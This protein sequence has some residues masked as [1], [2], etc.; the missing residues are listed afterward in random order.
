MLAGGSLALAAGLAINAFTRAYGIS[1][2]GMARSRDAA[3]AVEK[4]Q[5][6]L[7]PAMLGTVCVALSL[8][9]PEVLGALARVAHSVIGVNISPELVVGNLTVIPAHLDF[10]A[11]SPTYLAVFLVGVTVVPLVIYAAGRPRAPSRI[12]P[13]W[14]GG[15]LSYR[16]RMQYTATT[17]ANP[18]RVTFDRLYWPDVHL[19]RAS[20]DPAGRSGPVHY[21]FEVLPL[22][23]RYLYA[24]IVRAVR[25]LGGAIRPLQSGD[26]NHYLL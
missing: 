4:G 21:R 26:V 1:F 14:D 24:P 9:A 16:S 2:L 20:D 7:G 25:W 10:S 8:G 12:T 22:F 15:I 23:E 3:A 13:V 6:L 19:E 18:V 11:F 17:F 5:P